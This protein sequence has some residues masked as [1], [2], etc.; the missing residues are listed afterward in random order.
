MGL[1]NMDTPKA[2]LSNEVPFLTGNPSFS[3]PKFINTGT[4]TT[5]QEF[6]LFAKKTFT[7]NLT[8]NQDNGSNAGLNNA[9]NLKIHWTLDFRSDHD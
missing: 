3:N 8:R 4:G 6:K 2:L 1:W 9:V 7:D 5:S